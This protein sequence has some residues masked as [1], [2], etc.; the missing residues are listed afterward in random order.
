MNLQHVARLC[1][2]ARGNMFCFFPLTYV[3]E[4]TIFDRHYYPHE[5][6]RPAAGWISPE[7]LRPTSA[8]CIGRRSL[9]INIMCVENFAIDRLCFICYLDIIYCTGMFRGW[10]LPQS[11]ASADSKVR[12]SL[13][14]AQF[15]PSSS[16]VFLWSMLIRDKRRT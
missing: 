1:S 11:G 10:S 12:V 5:L 7:V 2:Q 8:D 9:P 6:N 4:T 13:N 3:D 14:Q 16:L 15:E